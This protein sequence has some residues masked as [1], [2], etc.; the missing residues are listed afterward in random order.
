[1]LEQVRAGF[2]LQSVHWRFR[3]KIQ[4]DDSVIAISQGL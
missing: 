1:M 4:I 2:V 3:W